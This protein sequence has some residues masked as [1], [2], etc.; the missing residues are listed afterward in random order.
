[1]KKAEILAPAGNMDSLIAG[2]R[3][4]ADAVYLGGKELSARRNAA[5]FTDEEL[6]EAVRY[7]HARGVKVYLTLNTLA[8]DSEMNIALG[9][10]ERACEIN[11]DALILQDLGIAKL[12]R[13]AAPS[14]PLHASTQ[15]SVHTLSGLF[16]L[17]EM[18][19]RRAV[20]ARELSRSELLELAEKSPI[21][22]EVFVHGALCM[23]VSGQCYLSSVLGA[24][25]GNR[26]LCAQPCRL[27]F[28][29]PGGV[30]HALSLKDLSLVE[31]LTELEDLGI[32]SFKIEGRM[33]RPEYVAAAVT[34]C[35]ASLDGEYSGELMNQ[36]QSVFSRSGF[37][38]GYY[39]SKLGN[40]MF[41]IR[42][43][44]DVVSAK[45]VLSDLEKLYG[46]EKQIVPT[47]FAFTA[48]SGQLSP[49][50]LRREENPHLQNR[51]ASPNLQ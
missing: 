30:R 26:G 6:E 40:D 41:G 21:D 23:S 18:G 32:T 14:M 37:T 8:S 28:L 45:N 19:F 25:S 5:N 44:E 2:V 38:N 34:A 42:S 20:L 10:I 39:F 48:I 11:A 46:K 50:P 13:E 31:S 36:L 24:R 51:T 33:K 17:A 47:D 29:A 7:C 1:M 12:A 49:L 9:I 3:C 43:K 16:E 22:L 35:R 15:M 27:P 4:G